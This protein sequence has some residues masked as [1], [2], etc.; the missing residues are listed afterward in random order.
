MFISVTDQWGQSI[1]INI[2]SIGLIKDSK[3]EARYMRK[4]TD[5]KERY[6]TNSIITSWDTCLYVQERV[7]DLLPLIQKGGE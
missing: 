3:R 6:D 4:T 2:K 5:E 7:S 1:W